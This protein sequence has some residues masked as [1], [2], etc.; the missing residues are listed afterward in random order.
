MSTEV[1]CPNC[2]SDMRL[3]TAQRGKNAGNQFYGCS[4]YPNCKGILTLEEHKSGHNREEIPDSIE[5]DFFVFPHKMVAR[6][7]FRNYQCVFVQ[8]VATT[9][10][11]ISQVVPIELS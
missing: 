4:K 8:S 2:G 5:K 7:I 9:L 6:S 3:R 10:A 11:H 1:K